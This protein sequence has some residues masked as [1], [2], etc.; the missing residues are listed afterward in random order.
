MKRIDDG[1]PPLPCA[2]GEF[3]PDGPTGCMG[4]PGIVAGGRDYITLAATAGIV[5]GGAISPGEAGRAC[6]VCALCALAASEALT[7]PA[8]VALQRLLPTPSPQPPH[9]AR[10][11]AR[12]TALSAAGKGSSRVRKTTAGHAWC[13]PFVGVLCAHPSRAPNAGCL[14]KTAPMLPQANGEWVPLC[15]GL[16]GPSPWRS[17]GACPSYL[18]DSNYSIFYYIGQGPLVPDPAKQRAQCTGTLLLLAS[19]RP[20]LHCAPNG[21]CAGETHAWMQTAWP[22]SFPFAVFWQDVPGYDFL[23]NKKLTGIKVG[24]AHRRVSACQLAAACDAAPGC[25]AFGG[26]N[27]QTPWTEELQLWSSAQLI[28]CTKPSLIG[29]PSCGAWVKQGKPR[30]LDG[31]AARRCRGPPAAT[32]DTSHAHLSLPPIELPPVQLRPTSPI[33]PNKRAVNSARTVGQMACRCHAQ[34]PA[35]HAR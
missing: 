31:A 34:L 19:P 22:A 8:A 25:V 33:V 6:T 28:N 18:R 24:E 29:D 7:C 2:G 14:S 1:A 35:R 16:V 4:E 32:S 3:W 26:Y 27:D 12:P 11:K 10:C 13:A 20:M 5:Y 23:P 30:A 21:H 15:T 9:A 17:F